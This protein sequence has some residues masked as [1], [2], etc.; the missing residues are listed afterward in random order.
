MGYRTHLTLTVPGQPQT[1]GTFKD[2]PT[3]VY[4]LQNY[5]I[6]KVYFNELPEELEQ[7]HDEHPEEYSIYFKDNG[8]SDD[9][10]IQIGL[11]LAF[12]K[13]IK[14]EQA[15][16][17]ADEIAVLPDWLDIGVDHIMDVLEK[18][19]KEALVHPTDV[20]YFECY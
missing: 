10:E 15:G 12:C 2:M 4:L 11:L 20:I 5:C 1:V 16:K 18:A 9:G 3:D 13:R 17:T 7:I 8:N 6:G 19:L 14:E